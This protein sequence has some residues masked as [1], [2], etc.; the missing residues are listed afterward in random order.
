MDMRVQ[1]VDH[2]HTKLANKTKITS[3]LFPHGIN[4]HPFPGVQ[5]PE[6]VSEGRCVLMKELTETDVWLSTHGVIYQVRLR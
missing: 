1:C 3:K 2:T 5:I 4:N 6:E